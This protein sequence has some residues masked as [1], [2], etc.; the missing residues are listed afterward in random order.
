MIVILKQN[1]EENV[2]NLSEEELW[3]RIY[4]VIG[5]NFDGR[6]KLTHINTAT[7]WTFKASCPINEF[8]SFRFVSVNQLSLLVEG[9]DFVITPTG[10]I[11]KK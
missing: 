6:I 8:S 7:A 4:S 3:K 5:I 11:I 10:E 9:N 1:E 2:F